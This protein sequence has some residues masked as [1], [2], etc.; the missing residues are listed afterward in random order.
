[1]K[2][3]SAEAA[4]LLRK[5]NENLD[6]LNEKERRS[7]DFVA[8]VGEEIEDVRPEYDYRKTQDE[9]A[10]IEQK[11]RTVKHAINQF[12]TRTVVQDFDM[13]VDQI[14]VYIPQ[15]TAKKGKLS[16]MAARLPKERCGASGFGA[17]TIIEYRYANYDIAA[18]EAD[19]DAVAE[20]LA[21]A[22]TALD[23]VNNREVMDISFD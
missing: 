5:L 10:Q 3:T 4:K 17:K 21:R 22:Q 12:N 8:A 14:L 19:L 23:V 15:L 9:I 20:E 7:A 16:R 2:Y 11:I 6:A 1:M 13:T 18:V